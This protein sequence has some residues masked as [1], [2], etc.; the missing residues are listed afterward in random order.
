VPL[1]SHEGCGP[2]FKTS[3]HLGS[4]IAPLPFPKGCGR[5]IVVRRRFDGGLGEGKGPG[6]PMKWEAHAVRL[7]NEP[8]VRFSPTILPTQPY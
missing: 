5:F 1:P 7:G 8:R 6:G 4:E 2:V 3:T